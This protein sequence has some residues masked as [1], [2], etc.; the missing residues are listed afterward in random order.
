MRYR[1][2]SPTGDYVFGRG[3][4]EFLVNSPEAVAQAVRTRL[5]LI[6]GEWYLDT[7]EGT[8][9]EEAILGMHKQG[10]Y[11]QAIKERILGTQGVLQID[12][13]ASVLNQQRELTVDCLI[14]TIYGPVSI[15][16][17]F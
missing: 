3:T 16:Q 14:S 10:L 5:L 6:T 2:L 13:Y 8:P 12:R 9:Y 11:D 17:V 15:S 4:T 1:S 7:A